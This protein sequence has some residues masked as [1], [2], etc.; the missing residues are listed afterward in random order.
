MATKPPYPHDEAPSNIV[1]KNNQEMRETESTAD[2]VGGV[3]VARSRHSL[4]APCRSTRTRNRHTRGFPLFFESRNPSIHLI[5]RNSGRKTAGHF[6]WNCSRLRIFRERPDGPY[7]RP[8]RPKT[9][10][11]SLAA[12]DL[13]FQLTRRIWWSQSESNRRPHPCLGCA[14]PIELQPRGG[15]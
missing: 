8:N 14:L 6:S 12:G 3:C 13:D 2:F 7:R 4:S 15:S 1:D 10:D 11:A 5:L 9:Q